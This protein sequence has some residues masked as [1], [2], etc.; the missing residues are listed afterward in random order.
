MS[1]NAIRTQADEIRLS[2]DALIVF[3]NDN[4]SLDKTNGT[5]YSDTYRVDIT[6]SN[7]QFPNLIVADYTDVQLFMTME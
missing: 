3:V 7:F 1:E 2:A 5:F 6:I 4:K